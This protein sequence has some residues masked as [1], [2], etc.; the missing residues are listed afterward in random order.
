MNSNDTSNTPN[1]DTATNNSGRK[2]IEPRSWSRK[3]FV[4]KDK[5]LL[6]CNICF[7][8]VKIYNSSTTQLIDHLKIHNINQNNQPNIEKNHLKKRRLD[9]SSESENDEN[10]FDIAQNQT[11]ITIKQKAKINKY[12]MNFILNNNLPFNIVESPDF[13]K[14]IDI[15]KPNYYELPCRQTVRNTLLNE[16]VDSVKLL[17]NTEIKSV[18]FG[19]GTSDVWTSN[20]NMAYICFTFHYVNDYLELKNRVLCLKYLND[21]HSSD[22]LHDSLVSIMREWNVL[23]KTFAI[24]TDSGANMKGAVAKF[25]NDMLKLPCAAH[26]LNSCVTDLLNIKKIKIKIDKNNNQKFFI[27]EYDKLGKCKDTEISEQEAQRIENL[28]FI[29]SEILKKLTSKCK[30]LVGLFRHSEQNTRIFRD[31]QDFLIKQ[32]H[33]NYRTK[34]VQDVPTRWNST[35]D[36]LE[37]ILANK[38]VLTSLSCENSSIKN[39]MLSEFEFKQVDELCKILEPLKDLTE[40][41]S[42]SKYVTCSILHP[43]IYTLINFELPNKIINDKYLIILKDELKTILKKRYSYILEN[44]K[45]DFFIAAT[46]LDFNYKKFTYV[47]NE[48]ESF[49]L[50]RRAKN[51]IK[52]LGN[53]HFNANIESLSRQVNSTSTNSLQA[54]QMSTSQIVNNC[55]QNQITE[56]IPLAQISRVHRKKERNYLNKLQDPVQQNIQT[57]TTN[58]F[59][60]ELDKEFVLY[61]NKNFHFDNNNDSKFKSLDFFKIFEIE[62]PLITKIVKI[63]FSVTAT[64]V[65]AESLFSCAGL[66][67]NESRNRLD[68]AVLDKINFVKSNKFS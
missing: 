58:L 61:D 2:K 56:S 65:P 38:Y 62:L 27:R 48:S 43:A 32:K 51:F 50:I 14:F 53:K 19:S 33:L 39:E 46:Y 30:R 23:N 44:D 49:E 7:I 31:K 24:N 34:L 26:K 42:G 3:Y 16:M 60:E 36:M 11:K 21:S 28:N 29:R 68:P 8:E 52:N 45:N 41:L 67:Q 20:S 63:I 9:F 37:S 66:I 10:N 35:Y 59:L 13:Q 47:Q 12:L 40:F 25:S 64:S 17:L 55:S 1:F 57:N 18:M 22:Y 4:Q 15:I 6:I 54:N 5:N